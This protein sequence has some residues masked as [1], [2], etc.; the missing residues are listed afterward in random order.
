MLIVKKPL[1]LLLYKT[2]AG[3]CTVLSEL[4]ET[5]ISECAT[6]IKH[7]YLSL[8]QFAP[9]IGARWLEGW[10]PAVLQAK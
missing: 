3:P 10:V 5:F 6:K 1:Y 2:A 9:G 8:H 4:R 7:T